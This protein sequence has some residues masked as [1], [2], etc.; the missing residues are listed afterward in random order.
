MGFRTNAWAKV[1]DVEEVSNAVT[2]IN[3]STSKKNKSTNK[4]ETDF[5][6]FARCVGT[7]CASKALKLKKGDTIQIG[8]CEVT[9]KYYPQKKVSYTNYSIFSFEV[10]EKEE[11][12][13]PV[14]SNDVEEDED[15]RLPF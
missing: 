3:I 1:W 7:S 13:N 8:D 10:D 9:T 12:V 2:K 4:Y 6:G 11:D 5:S 14:D 15:E